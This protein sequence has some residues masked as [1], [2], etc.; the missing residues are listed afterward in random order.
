[1]I[2][3]SHFPY[4]DRRLYPPRAWALSLRVCGLAREDKT[5][6]GPSVTVF[7]VEARTVFP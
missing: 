4:S 6:V 2:F 7:A 3:P 1:M 5:S